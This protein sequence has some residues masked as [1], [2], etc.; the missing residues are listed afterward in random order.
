MKLL[1]LILILSFLSISCSSLTSKRTPATSA[2]FPPDEKENIF[3]AYEPLNVELE[4]PLDELFT[5]IDSKPFPFNKD[6]FVLGVLSYEDKT[7]QKL[8]IPVR[9]H[10]KGFSTTVLCS[11]TKLELKLKDP[12]TK[13]T[14]FDSIK[15]IDLNTHCADP[16]VPHSNAH[17]KS[18][19][20]NHREA[21][22]YRMAHVLEIPTLRARPVFI[23]YTKTQI[24]EVDLKPSPYQAF[25]LEDTPYLRK[26]LKGKEIKSAVDTFKDMEIAKDPRKASQYVFTDVQSSPKIDK[27]DVAR[28]ELFQNMIANMDWFIKMHPHHRRFQS[29][30]NS[31]N[32][33]NIRILEL[34]SGQWVPFPQDFNFTGA[35]QGLQG[36][37]KTEIF[38]TVSEASRQ[39]L[40]NIFL[41]KKAQ[42][43]PLTETLANDPEGIEYIRKSLDV[44][45]QNLEALP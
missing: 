8:Q 34:P 40:K 6:L 29:E 35:V 10:I 26:R 11:F 43:Y 24:P 39:K 27:E 19:L 16:N 33:W 20:K 30:E 12:D 15:S 32:L 28:I 14:L 25:F 41:S 31:A 13:G 22:L 23:R 21:L 44:F 42:L 1:K 17:I 5:K 45:Y 4:A 2:P 7:H 37:F 38:N 3:S 9:V 36:G 18:A